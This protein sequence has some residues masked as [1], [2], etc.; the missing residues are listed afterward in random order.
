[1]SNQASL[2]PDILF[3]FSKDKDTLFDILNS[4]FRVSYARE[5]VE[6]IDTIREFG[7]P[8]VSFCDLKLSELKVHMGKYGNF[9][10]GLTKNWANRNGLNPVMYVSKHCPFTD[11]F[12]NSLNSVFKKIGALTD[13]YEFEGISDNNIKILDAYRYIKTMKAHLLVMKKL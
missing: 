3:H 8:M 13:N 1:M 5:K 10:I 12:N 9:G 7:V 6:G 2:Y 4:T 11:N